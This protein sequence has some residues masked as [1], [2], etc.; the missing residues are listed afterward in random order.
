MS[1]FD[2]EIVKNE[3]QMTTSLVE[4]FNSHD[5]SDSDRTETL[6]AFV[7]KIRIFH[8]RLG[9]SDDIE[10]RELK[11]EFDKQAKLLGFLNM[12]QCLNWLETIK[13]E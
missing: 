8:A 10:A 5:L 7:D 13:L 6:Q 12:T 1:F 3:M 2:S 9:F 11:N 4:V